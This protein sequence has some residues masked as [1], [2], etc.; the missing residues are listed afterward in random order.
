MNNIPPNK[1]NA[2]PERRPDAQSS[3]NANRINSLRSPTPSGA[4]RPPRSAEGLPRDY[5]HTPHTHNGTPSQSRRPIGPDGRP[6]SPLQRSTRPT[7]GRP[8]SS[9]AVTAAHENRGLFLLLGISIA[10]LIA[11]SVAFILITQNCGGD[12]PPEPDLPASNTTSALLPETEDM[13]QQYIDSMIFVGDSNTAHLVGFGILNGGKDTRQV[14]VPKGSTITL[15]SEITNKTVEYPE[16]GEFMTIAEAAAKRK[17]EYLVISLGTNGIGYL[18]ESQFKYCYKKLL[19]AVKEASPSTKI[20]VQSIYP[21]TSWYEGISNDKINLANTWLLALAQECGVAYADTASVLRDGNGFLKEE[22]NSAHR[23]GYHI[24]K[25]AA[26]QI[27]YY[28]RTH[29]YTK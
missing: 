28:L 25:T 1:R 16:T 24:N 17:P 14:W 8:T 4:P 13:G 15:D 5:R 12:K 11:L 26:E 19:D 18:N 22:Y 10:V 27:I 7:E 3:K 20:I 21:V 23:D 29:G 9:A 2:P 6:A